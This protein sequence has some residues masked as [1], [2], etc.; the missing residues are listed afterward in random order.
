MFPSGNKYICWDLETWHQKVALNSIIPHKGTVVLMWHPCKCNAICLFSLF[1][2]CFQLHHLP[3]A[4][5]AFRCFV[6]W[7]TCHPTKL[8]RK[9]C[10]YT[11]QCH[12]K[13]GYF[14]MK[15]SETLISEEEQWLYMVALRMQTCWRH[16]PMPALSA[17][18]PAALGPLEAMA[19][20]RS[21]AAGPW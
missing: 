12:V 10:I 18:R 16:V 2:N 20:V 11:N 1:L 8:Q 7:I 3:D 19:Q 13:I 4:L 6:F 17:V 14:V 15:H 21:T 9:Q 5:L